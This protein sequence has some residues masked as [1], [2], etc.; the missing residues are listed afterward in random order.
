M[1]GVNKISCII[2]WI[3]G[4]LLIAT[5]STSMQTQTRR[6]C[7]KN[8]GKCVKGPEVIMFIVYS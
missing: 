7:R 1:F 3:L 6:E 8:K 5:L 2:Y 4:L